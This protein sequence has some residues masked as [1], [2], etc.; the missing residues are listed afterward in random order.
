MNGGPLAGVRVIEIGR[1]I[2]APYAG[3]LLADLGADVVKVEDP[4]G[5]DPMRRWEGGERPYSPQFAA[6]NRGKRSVCLDLKSADG[7]DALL[8]LAARSDIL[9]ENFR[10]GVMARLGVGPDVLTARNP[11]LVYCAVTGFGD[12]GPYAHRPSYDSV[13]SA[14]G[15]LY[16]L[17][18]PVSAPQPVGP[19][20]SDLLS[21]A[22][23]VQGV[24]AALHA[25]TVSG[26]GQVVG[27][28][29]LGSVLSF[30]TEAV[31]SVSE[32]GEALEPITRQRRAQAYGCVDREGHAFVVHLSVPDKFWHALTTALEHEEWRADPRFATR[33]A[34]YE[35][36]A[37]LDA[38]IKQATRTRTR[39][40]WF[41]RFD[42]LDL[43]HGPLNTI[44]DVLDDP[45]VHAAGLLE[46]VPM[47]D[48]APLL[49]TRPANRF[50]DSE[51]D[52]LLP[53]PLLGEHTAEVLAELGIT[54]EVPHAVGA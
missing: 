36:Y 20:L 43:P 18:M 15:G 21:G 16:S 49:S 29:M 9:I 50:S 38:L 13:T 40:E 4:D 54:V 37:E 27:T 24:L 30:L 19:A 5:G 47:P 34:R 31:T 32:T 52:N 42:E 48:A 28:T 35:N 6:Y 1:Y 44:A 25:R 39:A 23:A 8:G 14:I 46:H 10:P 45:Q 7:R 3:R 2:G 17:L 53:P 12:S 26:K 33:P 41:A 11:R 51:P 22:F